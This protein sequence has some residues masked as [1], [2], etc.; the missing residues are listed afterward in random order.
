MVIDIA[1]SSGIPVAIAAI[2]DI[3]N[4]LSVIDYF[5]IISSSNGSFSNAGGLLLECT[6]C[7][8]GLIS[9]LTA[10]TENSKDLANRNYLPNVVALASNQSSLVTMAFK[11]IMDGWNNNNTANCQIAIIIITD[12]RITSDTA[13]AVASNNRNLQ[14]MYQ[15]DPAK[16]FVTSLTDDLAGYY[17]TMAIQLTCNHSGIWNKVFYVRLC[18]CQPLNS[19]CSSTVCY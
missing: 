2:R 17:D 8:I 11:A 18:V 19:L 12:R 4:T 9:G 5:N 14:S 3:L 6:E 7:Y 1:N 15:I 13:E 16:L 10:A